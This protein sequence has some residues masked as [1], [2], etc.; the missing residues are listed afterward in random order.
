M[1]DWRE[2]VRTHGPLVWQ[3][4]YRLL[5]H[6]ADTA[7][8]FQ[9][10]FLAAVELAAGEPVRNWPALLRQLATAR[11]LEQIRRR[12][13]ARGRTEPLPAEPADCR[14]GEPLDSAAGGEL[15]DAL[16]HALANIDPRQ[17]EVFCLVALGGQSYSEA[18]EQLGMTANHVG[19]LLARARV[20]LRD[21]LV[22]FDPSKRT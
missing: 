18:A 6:E 7:D 20:A 15:A 17:A 13:R 8:C 9:Q 1:T 2:V 5:A 19:V 16:R 10:T 3:T 14:A 11:A 22:V 4:A 21:R 12:V